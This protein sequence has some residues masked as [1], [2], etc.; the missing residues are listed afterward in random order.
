[1]A[2]RN[3]SRLN[4][5]L[6]VRPCMPST[7]R[8]QGAWKRGSSGSTGTLPNPCMPPM[9]WTPFTS[10]LWA[11]ICASRQRARHASPLQEAAEDLSGG[12]L[13]D[14]VGELDQADALVGS[15]PPRDELHQLL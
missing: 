14:L 6:R 2:C 9:S 11:L 12:G 7:L 13:R 1:M 10:R 3:S 4:R 5:P 15:H 8:S